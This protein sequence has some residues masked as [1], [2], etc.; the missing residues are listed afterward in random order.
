MNECLT[1]WTA[2]RPS[3]CPSSLKASHI[4]IVLAY[5]YFFKDVPIYSSDKT[6]TFWALHTLTLSRNNTYT[7]CSFR[8]ALLGL[9]YCICNECLQCDVS[10]IEC[11]KVT[12]SSTCTYLV[13]HIFGYDKCLHVS[14]ADS[15]ATIL[16][17]PTNA[18]QIAMLWYLSFLLIHP[19]FSS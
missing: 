15:C 5:W 12:F 7:L 6:A 16:V 17:R 1:Y 11:P 19:P 18:C 9:F 2:L 3:K 10:S 14:C 8:S 4:Y 13:K